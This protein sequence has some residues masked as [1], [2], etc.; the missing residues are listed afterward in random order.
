MLKPYEQRRIDS[1]EFWIGELRGAIADKSESGIVSASRLTLAR[2]KEIRAYASPEYL[3][4]SI[5][6]IFTELNRA[7]EVLPDLD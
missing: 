5:N 4:R 3:A 2:F 1:F 6:Y 7:H